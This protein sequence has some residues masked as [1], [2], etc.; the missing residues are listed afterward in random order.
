MLFATWSLTYQ[1]LKVSREE[2]S[3]STE[4]LKDNADTQ[5]EIQKTQKLQQFDSLFF[6]LLKNFQYLNVFYSQHSQHRH[7][8]KDIFLEKKVK[9]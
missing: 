8:Y 9:I 1:T 7:L 2:L 4:A 5:K 3:K 6:N